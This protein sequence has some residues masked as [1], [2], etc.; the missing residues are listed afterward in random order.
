M[1]YTTLS[2]KGEKTNIP[3]VHTG[4]RKRIL[5]KLQAGEEML[6]EHEFLEVF[7]FNALP[8][9][10]TNDLAHRLLCEF[11]D[12]KA[13][14]HA[15]IERLSM[16]EGIGV[17]IAEY[18]RVTGILLDKMSAEMKKESYPVKFNLGEFASFI[19]REYAVLGCEVLDVYV[20]DAFGKIYGRKRFTSDREA[21]VEVQLSWLMEIVVG[22]SPM[23]VLLV[24]NHPYGEAR[25][26]E[27]DTATTEECR[28][29]C[30]KNGILFCDHFIFAPTGIYSYNLNRTLF[31]HEYQ[32][33]Q[34]GADNA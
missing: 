26:S 11:G 4:H 34:S 16:V 18:I 15:P 3:A 29:L 30:E 8:R 6:C 24:H 27:A 7:L 14:F 13:V 17:N 23:G 1:G 22:L 5:K 9:R 21:R 19:N 28:Q 25:P 20:L 31:A 32:Q 2:K 10:N 33:E 12:L